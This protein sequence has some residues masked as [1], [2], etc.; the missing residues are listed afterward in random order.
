MT[1]LAVDIGGTKFAAAAVAPDGEMLA[2][3]EVPL[4][5]L[6]SAGETLSEVVGRIIERVEPARLDGIGIGS[7]GPL[8]PRRGTVSPVNIPTWREFPLVDALG[9]MLPGRPV[10]LAGDAQCMALG[11]WWRGLGGDRAARSRAMLGVVVSTGVGGGFVLDGVPYVGPTGNAGHIGHITVDPGGEPCPCGGVGCVETIASGPGMVRWATANGWTGEDA[12]ALA[13]DAGAGHP[14]AAR[15]FR[16]AAD[17]LA[18]AVLTASAL[19]DL[20]HVVIGGGVAAA[21]PILFDPLR[22]AIE[23]NAGLGFLRRLRVDPTSLGR[24]AGLFGAA[25]LVLLRDGGPGA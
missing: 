16:R 25:A 20:D 13:A 12:R 23:R 8:D 2:R 3:A 9:E 5:G 24:D 6:A 22:Q 21:G 10:R 18:T 19:F 17:A 1:V 7:A 15:A 11:E 4:R 14:T